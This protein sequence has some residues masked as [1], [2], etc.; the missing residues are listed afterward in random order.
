MG[1]EALLRHHHRS[2]LC[3]V[4]LR[5]ASLPAIVGLKILAYLDRRPRW[6]LRDIQD[7]H[8]MLHRAEHVNADE[9][10]AAECMARPASDEL[11]FGE[12]GAYLLGRDVG[13]TFEESTLTPIQNLLEDLV[14]E[15]STVI[16]DIQQ[17]EEA[18]HM[19]RS[20]IRARLVAFHLGVLD[21]NS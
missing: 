5:S 14:L 16:G 12:A 19:P 20:L 1:L 13:T 9:R 10:I 8:F 2:Q 6:I 3:G 18:R 21:R 7:V 15:S 11:G 4:A 17:S